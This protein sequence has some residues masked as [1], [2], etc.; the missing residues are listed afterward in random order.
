MAASAAPFAAPPR[1]S[2][3]LVQ[4]LLACGASLD[5]RVVEY[6]DHLHEHFAHPVVVRNGRYLVPAD[7]GYSATIKPASLDEHE[8]PTGAVWRG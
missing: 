4:T 5:N 2:R 1:W 8:F 7:P 3:T 6:V